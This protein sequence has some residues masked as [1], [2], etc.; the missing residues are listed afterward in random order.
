MIIDAGKLDRIVELL[1]KAST[2]DAAGQGIDTWTVS[3]TVAAQRLTLRA[4]LSVRGER[5]SRAIGGGRLGPLGRL[6]STPTGAIAARSLIYWFRDAR[7][8]RQLILR[9]KI[10]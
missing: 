8:A 9:R 4:S 6:P 1:T 5:S 10:S 3:V 7:L 2:R